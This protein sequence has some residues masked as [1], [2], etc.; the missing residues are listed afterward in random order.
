M[1]RL[2]RGATEA[3]HGVAFFTQHFLAADQAAV[4]IGNA[5]ACQVD[6]W[7]TRTATF[8]GNNSMKY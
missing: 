7:N 6:A 2:D 8:S 5:L 4:R 3:H 1:N